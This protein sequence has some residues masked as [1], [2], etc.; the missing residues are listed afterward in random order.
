[1]R[2]ERGVRE[3][4]GQ[5]HVRVQ[6]RL[7]GRRMRGCERVRRGVR[8]VRRQRQVHKRPG[9]V[10]VPVPPGFRR[11]RDGILPKLVLSAARFNVCLRSHFFPGLTRCLSFP[12]LPLGAF[13]RVPRVFATCVVG[14]YSCL[15][16][17]AV[18]FL[19]FTVVSCLFQHLY[20]II[21]VHRIVR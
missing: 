21:E 3:R 16:T 15:R 9:V 7:R 5:L 17:A 1:M 8:P 2:T 18:L 6:D 10:R 19:L 4:D 20:I 14:Q 11:V 13:C 12:R